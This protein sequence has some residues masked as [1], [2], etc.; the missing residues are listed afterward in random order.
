[1]AENTSQ[2]LAPIPTIPAGYAVRTGL[3]P[4]PV[5]RDLRS[6]A[7]IIPVTPQQA[8]AAIKGSWFGCHIVHT[9]AS[10]EETIVGMGG[11]IANGSWYF[12]IVDIAILP[13]HQRKGLGKLVIHTLMEHILANKAEGRPFI[14]L[15]ASDEGAS[16]YRKCAFM[17]GKKFGET[18]MVW[19][20]TYPE[21]VKELRDA[22]KAQS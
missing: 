5:Y 7:G 17:D 2:T 22:E 10:S 6:R 11:V 18:G 8:E 16:L 12:H 4:A 9:S 20:G 3:P 21:I 13:E 19:E 1:M 15:S 14:C